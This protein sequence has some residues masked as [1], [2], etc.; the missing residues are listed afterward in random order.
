MSVSNIHVELI[1]LKPL[2]DEISVLSSQATAIPST[3]LPMS[4]QYMF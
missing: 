1:S 4:F 3:I 2:L